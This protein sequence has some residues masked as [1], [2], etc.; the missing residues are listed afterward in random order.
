MHGKV[1]QSTTEKYI[2]R[3][4]LIISDTICFFPIRMSAMWNFNLIAPKVP[5]WHGGMAKKVILGGGILLPNL[6]PMISRIL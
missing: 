3:Q 6:F 5:F 1:Q 2:K 4:I